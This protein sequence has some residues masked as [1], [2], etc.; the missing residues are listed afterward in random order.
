[1]KQT[2]NRARLLLAR[3]QCRLAFTES[4]EDKLKKTAYLIHTRL[5]LPVEI[6]FSLIK[7]LATMLHGLNLRVV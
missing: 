1:M 5:S 7:S 2:K 3:P 4:G 6:V